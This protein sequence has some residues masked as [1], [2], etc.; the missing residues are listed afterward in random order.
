MIKFIDPTR[1]VTITTGVAQRG[2]EILDPGFE[3]V[4]TPL[5]V[6]A[7]TEL[8]RLIQRG[9]QSR[10]GA[11]RAAVIMAEYVIEIEGVT[12]PITPEL[13]NSI[14]NIAHFWSMAGDLCL[15]A[16]LDEVTEKNSA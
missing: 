11:K 5:D 10:E 3:I 6:P 15:H 12:Q 9:E 1:P 7:K 16:T 2:D 14:E 8:M 4:F 13:L